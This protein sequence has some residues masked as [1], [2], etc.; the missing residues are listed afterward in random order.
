[1]RECITHFACDC[2][3]ARIEFLEEKITEKNATIKYL[4]AKLG[5]ATDYEGRGD[6]DESVGGSQDTGAD[7]LRDGEQGASAVPGFP[8]PREV[9]WKA[10]TQDALLLGGEKKERK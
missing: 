4:R 8:D 6:Y 2:L 10:K 1:M 3:L 7:D 9:L 5:D